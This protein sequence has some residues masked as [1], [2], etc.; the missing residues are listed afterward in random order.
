LEAKTIKLKAS[1]RLR[2]SGLE[3]KVKNIQTS[4]RL[5]PDAELAI[6]GTGLATDRLPFIRGDDFLGV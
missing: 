3:L 2:K 1:K 5:D 4:F 6:L